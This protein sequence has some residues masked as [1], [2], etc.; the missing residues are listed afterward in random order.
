MR[1]TL[2][3]NIKT[4]RMVVFALAAAALVSGVF[5]FMETSKVPEVKSGIVQK[6]QTSNTRLP[7]YTHQLPVIFLTDT[8]WKARTLTTGGVARDYFFGSGNPTDLRLTSSDLAG[9]F[10]RPDASGQLPVGYI[11]EQ[12]EQL[13]SDFVSDPMLKRFVEACER[14]LP[15]GNSSNV[16]GKP[17][18]TML[19]LDGLVYVDA[20]TGRKELD[21][22]TLDMISQYF[23]VLD[24]PVLPEGELQ[25]WRECLDAN[26]Y[27]AF[28]QLQVKL[29][30]VYRNYLPQ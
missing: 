2:T 8:T 27:S 6:A 3:P 19:A 26:E 4:R 12:T 25:G 5:W 24:N 21:F 20:N 9:Y 29:S 13:L 15:I 11:N 18:P 7:T 28:E 10:A 23:H 30:N 16:F 22:S 17:F 1:I 14:F